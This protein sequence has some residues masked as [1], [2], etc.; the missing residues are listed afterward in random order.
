MIYSRYDFN[1]TIIYQLF[2][3]LLMQA[4]IL[5]KKNNAMLYAF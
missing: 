1:I 2:K 3:L 4:L 5:I